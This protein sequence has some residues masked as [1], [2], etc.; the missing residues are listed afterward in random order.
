VH[1]REQQFRRGRGY[2]GPLQLKDFLTLAGY[3]DP[4][5]LDFAPTKIKRWRGDDAIIYQ[6]F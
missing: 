6:R 4:H 2:P 5:S 3:L 1:P